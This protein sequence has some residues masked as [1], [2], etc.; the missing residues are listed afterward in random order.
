MALIRTC[1][2]EDLHAL[3]WDRMFHHH[4]EIFERTFAEHLAGRQVMLV[5]DVNGAP[6]GQ[7]WIDLFEARARMAGLIWAVRVHPAFHGRGLGTMLLQRSERVIRAHR[8]TAAELVVETSNDTARR[9]YERCGYSV[10]NRQLQT[11]SYKVPGSGLYE[12]ELDVFQMRKELT[13]EW[14]VRPSSAGP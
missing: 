11:Y 4:R 2:S 8:L 7:A 6:I 10:T 9:L 14:V 3:E 5:A 13:P 12:H 1:R